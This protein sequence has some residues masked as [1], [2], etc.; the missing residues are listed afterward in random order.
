M[1]I[2]KILSVDIMKKFRKRGVSIDR[3]GISQEDSAASSPRG[4]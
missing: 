2:Y 3:G 1:Q 4:I